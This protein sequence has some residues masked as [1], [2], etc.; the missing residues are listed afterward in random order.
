MHAPHSARPAIVD[1]SAIVHSSDPQL[2]DGRVMRSEC[3]GAR[4]STEMRTMTPIARYGEELDRLSIGNTGLI[5][6]P[7]S[8]NR[9]YMAYIYPGVS[10]PS[11]HPEANGDLEP[12]RPTERSMHPR[13]AIVLA[14]VALLEL[15]SAAVAHGQDQDT[16]MRETY[17]PARAQPSSIR[18]SSSM[19]GPG[20]YFQHS[21]HSAMLVVHIALMTIGWVFILPIGV[22][23]S[24]ARSRFSLPIQFIFLA[25]N[26]SGV[27]LA[28]VYNAK[29]PNLY[30]NNAHHKLGWALTWIMTAQVVMGIIRAY[31][32]GRRQSPTPV[33]TEAIAAHQQL[34]LLRPGQ[35]YRLSNDSGHGTEPSSESF[36]RDS[37]ASTDSADSRPEVDCLDHGDGEKRPL[38]DGSSMGKY[39]VSKIPRL[40]SARPLG[41][42]LFLHRAVDRLILI[43]M[44][45]AIATGIVTYGG[46]QMG[47]RVFSGL[48][49][50]IKGGLFFW[51]GILT[52]G[53]WAGCLADMGWAWNIRTAGNS[54]PSAEFVESFLIFSYGSTNVF[55]EHLAAWGKEWSAQDLEHVSL[56]LMFGG[57][58]LCGMVIE[59]HQI[60][61]L[62]NTTTH[63]AIPPLPSH[64]R[65]PRAIE[66]PTSYRFSMNPMPALVVLLLG[67]MMSSHHQESMVST[68]IHAQWGGLLMC[69]ALARGATYMLYYL[70]PPTS[71]LPGRP[72][73]EI[74]TAF[75]LMAGG[76]IFMASARDTV[77]ALEDNGLDAMFTFTVA[78][79]VITLL[80]AWI[81]LVIAM[82]GWAVKKEEKPFA[83]NS[84]A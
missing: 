3:L 74:I 69:A 32:G 29:T 62:L 21:E 79:G 31:A 58:G 82:K 47:D 75:C 7:T 4:L 68:M 72:P 43:L 84:S 77:R 5:Y 42:V 18:A 51:Y 39:L 37:R 19:A 76:M 13:N 49:H 14:S 11:S 25:V 40:V 55:L 60:R 30:P 22:M 67:K 53:R 20:T 56:T 24:I 38:L 78:M 83:S 15:L 52:L 73:T 10:P 41:V 9:Q 71:T 44:F 65:Y 48:A 2:E 63:S 34:H 66:E 16:T 6:S 57:A 70:S 45:V 28:A 46:L 80:M 12:W 23:F 33:S 64:P 35:T 81:I 27:F 36:G 59:S 17:P 50:W 1:P 54:W 26:A 8:F 61:N